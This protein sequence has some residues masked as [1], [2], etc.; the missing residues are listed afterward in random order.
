MGLKAIVL[1]NTKQVKG[2]REIKGKG[3]KKRCER[4]LSTFRIG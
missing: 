4:S 3:I 2:E 1:F